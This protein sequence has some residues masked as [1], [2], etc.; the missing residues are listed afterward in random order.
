[1]FLGRQQSKCDSSMTIVAPVKMD[2]SGLQGELKGDPGGFSEALV[3]PEN[4]ASPRNLCITQTLNPV[5]SG[6]EIIIQA[7][8]IS[9]TPVTVY[10]G[11]K[12]GEAV[13]RHSVFR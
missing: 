8:N 11:M 13:P 2:I 6:K 10:E 12:L 5:S 4:G 1:M 3:E 7:M 9:P